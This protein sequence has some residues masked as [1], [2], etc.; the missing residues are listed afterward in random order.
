MFKVN[1]RSQPIG[2]NEARVA[3]NKESS[4]KR[5]TDFNVVEVDL[6]CRRGDDVFY[7]NNAGR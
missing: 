3:D 2:L 4:E 5:G 6:D 1:K 7:G